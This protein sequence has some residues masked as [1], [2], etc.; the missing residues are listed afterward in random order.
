[1]LAVEGVFVGIVFRPYLGAQPYGFGIPRYFDGVVFE[2]R[3]VLVEVVLR[4][5]DDARSASL[6][7]GH[8][9]P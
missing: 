1:M 6:I 8:E 3:G 7:P 4:H 5:F 2:E 9:R